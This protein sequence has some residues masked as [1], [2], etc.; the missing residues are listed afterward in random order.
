MPSL[1]WAPAQ[2]YPGAVTSLPPENIR[3]R[4]TLASLP[5]YVP[6]APAAQD[7]QVRYKVSSNE[8]PFPPLPAVRDALVAQLDGL[9]RY[10]DL[11]AAA[12]RAELAG[13]HHVDPAQ[14]VVSTGSVAVAGDLVRA[15]VDQGDDVVYG[16]RSFEAY[17][18]LVGSHGGVGVGVPLT[19]GHE[20]DLDA[21]A[22]AIGERTRLVLLCSPNN[23]TGPALSTAQIEGFLARVPDT[24]AVAIDEA[25]REF[26]DPEVAPDTAGIF[27][28]HPNVVLL[29]TFSKIHGIAG[30]RIGYAV[31]HPRLAR[32]LAQVTV[33]FGAASLA[34]TAALACLRPAA[35]AELAQRA[36]LI[37]AQRH[38]VLAELRGQGW[39]VPDSQGN[40]VYLPLAERSAEFA[41]FAD[42]RGLVVRAYGNDGVRVTIAETEADDRLLEIT[43]LWRQS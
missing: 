40:F 33:P 22:D 13:I 15:L 8:S 28:A 26:V 27:A 24:V 14:I 20:L 1:H 43:D 11:G 23:P 30:L 35:R 12:L 16:W 31:A 9:N 18:I 34:Q 5:A 4:A 42:A 25:Y 3:L 6:G 39:E 19:A 2:T 37:R 32:A 17:P 41:A 38:R 29:R 7:G 10:P 36:A 21:M